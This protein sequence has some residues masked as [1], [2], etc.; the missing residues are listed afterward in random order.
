M[1]GLSYRS[2]MEKMLVSACL[3]GENTRYDGKNNEMQALI[4]QL[5]Q[6]YDLV[7]FCPEVA[8]GL[9]TP[10]IPSEI[11]GNQVINEKGK[12]V[13][14]AFQ[15]GAQEALRLCDFF[16]IKVALLKDGSPS[17]GSS[18]IYDGSFSHRKKDGMGVTAQLLSSHGVTVYNEESIATLLEGLKRRDQVRAERDR[19]RIAKAENEAAEQEQEQERHEQH[20]ETRKP[21]EDRERRPYSRDRKSYGERKPHGDHKRFG[22]KKPYGNRGEHKGPKGPYKKKPFKKHED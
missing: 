13:T 1:A 19:I 2:P 20:H 17:C 22:D 21:R 10:R 14:S 12:D 3:A 7:L 11:R 4:E 15:S 18:K 9:G 5:Q 8:G 16:Q 6:Y